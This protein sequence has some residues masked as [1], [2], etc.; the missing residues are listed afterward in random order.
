MGKCSSVD[1]VPRLSQNGI[2]AVPAVV[3]AILREGQLETEYAI[4]RT[5]H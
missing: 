2:R 5:H 1:A 3:D 4:D